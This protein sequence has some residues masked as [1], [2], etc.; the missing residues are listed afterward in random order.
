MWL[1]LLTPRLVAL[2]IVGC[3]AGRN[4]SRTVTADECV[5][6]VDEWRS[7]RTV[8]HHDGELHG[9][10]P[11]SGRDGGQRPIQKLRSVVRIATP[12]ILINLMH[13]SKLT[14]TLRRHHLCLMICHSHRRNGPHLSKARVLRS[15]YGW[16]GDGGV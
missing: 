15:Q 13:A 10:G 14:L 12:D 4:L 8:E 7:G 3:M 16:V 2:R 9:M 6:D 11:N 1:S 5:Y